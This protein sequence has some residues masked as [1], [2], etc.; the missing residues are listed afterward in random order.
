METKKK[1]ILIAT[2]GKRDVKLVEKN[3]RK[4][5][6]S[7]RTKGEEI[8]KHLNHYIE[9]IEIPI[10]KASLKYLINNGYEVDTLFLVVTDQKDP[11]FSKGDTIWFGEIIRKILK[12]KKF[13]SY[14]KRIGINGLDLKKIE[15]F[16]LTDYVNDFDVN[17]EFFS[18]NFQQLKEEMEI[19]NIYIEYSGGIPQINYSLILSALFHFD[20]NQIIPIVVDIKDM[21]AR[22]STI[23]SKTL[24]EINKIQLIQFIKRYD[25]KA[26]LAVIKG[27][28]PVIRQILRIISARLDFDFERSY[29]L[30]IDLRKLDKGKKTYEKL[31]DLLKKELNL[32]KR[33]EEIY[34]H[35]E[36]K[37]KNV[38]YLDFLS[39]FYAFY[40]NFMHLI[41]KP[42]GYYILDL[43]TENERIKAHN[44]FIEK[45]LELKEYLENKKEGL[46]FVSNI[47]TKVR[48]IIANFFYRG[49]DK[50]SSIKKIN[51]KFDLIIEKR[52][53]TII[54]HKL[55]GV[56]EKDF[57]VLYG[58][59]FTERILNDIKVFLDFIGVHAD[60]NIFDRI[61]DIIMDNLKAG[62]AF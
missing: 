26:P 33:L 7:V 31:N 34:Y 62:S 23:V 51:K 10:M 39:R 49:N 3:E 29:S 38:E 58:K 4:D 16:V 59:D 28:S 19:E 24:E 25:Y 43:E 13:K 9:F 50:F 17:F 57:S 5:I 14:R 37:L 1:N 53:K 45:N 48:Y 35:L 32:E 36:I 2:I 52:N 47:S 21:G 6:D 8:F 18:S 55:D 41:L 56:T 30:L 42:F 22:E 46:K 40:D 44:E 54:A 12:E 11:F 60:S 20:K 15:F 27:L 61:N